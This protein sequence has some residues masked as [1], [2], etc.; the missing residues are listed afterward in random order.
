MNLS[1][2]NIR[3][4]KFHN[5]LES[6]ETS[7]FENVFYKALFN[8]RKYFIEYLKKNISEKEVLNFGCGTGVMSQDLYQFKPKKTLG[9]DISEEAIKLAISSSKKLN[10]KIE[11]KVDN[12]EKTNLPSESFDLIYGV[13]IL[14]HLDLKK[15][16]KE[17]NRIL[18]KG[19]ST[20]FV[21]P[22]G[23]N[24]IINFY[25]FLTPK[26]R[27]IDEHPLMFKDLDLIKEHFKHTKIKYFGFLTVVFYLFYKN[28]E[29]SFFFNILS[30]LDNFIFKFKYFRFLAWSIII[31]AEK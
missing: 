5:I 28:P 13:S 31:I 6:S 15:S 18:R 9:I 11:F 1:E 27:S 10:M 14:H 23:T 21:E 25:R 30:K 17:I 19:G 4:K 8:L 26:S 3:E 16:I 29:K 7:R 22:L 24:P 2:I 12:C 20:I